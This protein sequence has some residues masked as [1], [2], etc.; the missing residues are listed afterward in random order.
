MPF[1]SRQIKIIYIVC[2]N[3]WLP[4]DFYNI[5]VLNH[6]TPTQYITGKKYLTYQWNFP[7]F[8]MSENNVLSNVCR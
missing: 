2:D 4:D 8:S 5:T 3:R 7:I 1:E 6:H